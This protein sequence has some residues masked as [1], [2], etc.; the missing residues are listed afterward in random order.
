MKKI[1]RRRS[2]AAP[3]AFNATAHL[4]DGYR[5]MAAD[6]NRERDAEEWVEGVIEDIADEPEPT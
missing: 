2:R 4:A 5:E 6:E 1:D 3:D